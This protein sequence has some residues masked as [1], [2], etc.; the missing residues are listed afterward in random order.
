[1][2]CFLFLAFWNK[3]ASDY[4]MARIYHVLS[5]L[6]YFITPRIFIVQTFVARSI[7]GNDIALL[8]MTMT[9][10]KKKF[11][12]KVEIDY[13]DTTH[14]TDATNKLSYEAYPRPITIIMVDI[15]CKIL[16]VVL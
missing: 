3:S 10:N 12:F 8:P 2:F 14:V 7:T 11:K 5:W 1:M 15:P 4:L 16:V 13:N 9:I 6:V